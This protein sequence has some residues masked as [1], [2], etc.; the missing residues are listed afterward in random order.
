MGSEQFH[1]QKHSIPKNPLFH[2]NHKLSE[3][4]VLSWLSAIL[5]RRNLLKEL[6]MAFFPLEKDLAYFTFLVDSQ[7]FVI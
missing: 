7:H 4:L 3:D 2:R 5:Q 6:L 1:K